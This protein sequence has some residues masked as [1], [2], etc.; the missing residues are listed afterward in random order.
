MVIKNKNGKE[1]LLLLG[2][3]TPKFGIFDFETFSFNLEK[4][5]WQKI[6]IEN[7]AI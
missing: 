1:N 6:K 4:K 7:A 3:I 5:I 2:G